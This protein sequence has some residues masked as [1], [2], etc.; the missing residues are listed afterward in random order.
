MGY[1]PD[2]RQPGRHG[3]RAGHALAATPK[4]TGITVDARHQHLDDAKMA[5]LSGKAAYS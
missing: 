5:E 4:L 1:A 3:T 2:N